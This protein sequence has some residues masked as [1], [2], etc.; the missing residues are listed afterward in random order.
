MDFW[1]PAGVSMPS[2]TVFFSIGVVLFTSFPPP[3]PVNPLTLIATAGLFLSPHYAARQLFLTSAFL[4]QSPV[5]CLSPG[6]YPSQLQIRQTPKRGV[7]LFLNLLVLLVT[8]FDR[9]WLLNFLMT[10]SFFSVGVV[11][12]SVFQFLFI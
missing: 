11:I 9:L 5:P 10:L 2:P 4:E 1:T 8:F 3:T 12:N 6:F 7:V